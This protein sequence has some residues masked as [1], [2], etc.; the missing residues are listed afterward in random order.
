MKE[1][2]TFALNSPT[3]PVVPAVAF[4]LSLVMLRIKKRYLNEGI[5]FGRKPTAERD[6]RASKE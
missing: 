6:H 2:L 4:V 1:L 5:L 3:L